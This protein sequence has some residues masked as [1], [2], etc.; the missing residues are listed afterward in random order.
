MR[1]RIPDPAELAAAPHLAALA[2]LEAVLIIAARATRAAVPR[3]DHIHVPLEPADLTAARILVEEADALLSV[4][5]DHRTTLLARL[6]HD[7]TKLDWP[8]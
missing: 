6:R 8:W 4:I 7:G 1:I 3:V 2:A 5:D